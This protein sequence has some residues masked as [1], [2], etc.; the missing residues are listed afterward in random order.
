MPLENP[1]LYEEMWPLDFS[2]KKEG[3]GWQVVKVAIL[4]YVNEDRPDHNVRK[5]KFHIHYPYH[6]NANFRLLVQLFWDFKTVC[7]VACL[8]PP[9][10][11]SFCP[12]R[13]YLFHAF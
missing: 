9:P 2:V 11:A 8:S 1:L 10:I 13:L 5:E 6:E 7:L 4:E 12:R 3:N